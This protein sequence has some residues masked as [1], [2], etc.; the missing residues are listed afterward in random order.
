[1]KSA[2]VFG[3]MLILLLAGCASA[4][5]KNVTNGTQNDSC[6]CTLEYNPVCGA[7]GKTY[8][9][10]CA[11]G[12]AKVSVAYPGECRSCN[13]T[14]S[15]RSPSV[16]GTATDNTGEHPDSC[17]SSGRLVEYYCDGGIAKSE[18]T[19]CPEGQECKDGSCVARPPPPAM[20]CEKYCPT[21]PHIECV[22]KWNISGTYPACSC[23][24]VCDVEPPGKGNLSQSTLRLFSG[25][26]PLPEG[27]YELWAVFGN[28]QFSLGKFDSGNDLKFDSQMDLSKADSVIV[29]IEPEGDANTAPGI[30][31]LS[32]EMENGKANLSFGASFIFANGTFLLLSATPTGPSGGEV[33]GLWFMSASEPREPGL[34]LPALPEGWVYEGWAVYKGTA[35]STGRFSSATGADSSN[36]YS[37]TGTAPQFPGEDFLKNGP[38]GLPFPARLTDGSTKVVISVEP[39]MEGT[40]PTGPGPFIIK[41]LMAEIEDDFLP[42][43]DY[44]LELDFLSMPP[45]GEVHVDSKA[46]D[47][48]TC[49]E[50]CSGQPHDACIGSWNVTG[51]YEPNC[52]CDWKCRGPTE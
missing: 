23:G 21:Q 42:G 12:C 44:P 22:G 7:D 9:N 6:I 41:P 24:F 35:L 33:S 38:A 1:M 4:P 3:S 25:L 37:G 36:Y 48:I 10:A 16:F 47:R 40:D 8:G 49:V 14:E 20:T 30:A 29:T 5:P 32:G 19:D 45:S 15:G 13:D 28:Q 34:S 39:D 11:A 50:F 18:G 52:T 51:D 46:G 31:Y 43:N 27:H 26:L 17:D 2:L